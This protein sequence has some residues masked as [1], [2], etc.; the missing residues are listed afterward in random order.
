MGSPRQE[1]AA[2]HQKSK[3]K[4]KGERTSR[5]FV[6]LNHSQVKGG[7]CIPEEGHPNKRFPRHLLQPARLPGQAVTSAKGRGRLRTVAGEEMG[8]SGVRAKRSCLGVWAT[9]PLKA[10]TLQKVS[11]SLGPCQAGRCQGTRKGQV[12]AG[13]PPRG[14]PL[15]NHLQ[16]HSPKLYITPVAKTAAAPRRART[17]APQPYT[18]WNFGA[19]GDPLSSGAAARASLSPHW[20]R[21]SRR[22]RGRSRACARAEREAAATLGRRARPGWEPPRARR[23]HARDRPS[24]ALSALTPAAP[25]SLPRKSG[26]RAGSGSP[27]TGAA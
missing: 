18:V 24:L 2:G 19:L 11:Q 26:R 16:K 9:I 22:A 14:H 1:K 15:A 4:R 25:S 7:G 21:P 17:A 6:F 3:D 5:F 23:G 20:S 13:H 8:K 10:R 27:R 12:V